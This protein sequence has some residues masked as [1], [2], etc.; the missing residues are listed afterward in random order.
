MGDLKS[1]VIIKER[2]EL[3]STIEMNHRYPAYNRYSPPHDEQCLVDNQLF[4]LPHHNNL[5]KELNDR[6]RIF[7]LPLAQLLPAPAVPNTKLSGRK[8]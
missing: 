5:E 3:L 4:R 7:V 6:S 8:I 1:Y 2:N